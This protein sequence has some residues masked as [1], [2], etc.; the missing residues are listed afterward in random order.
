MTKWDLKMDIINDIKSN[1]H[2]RA[3][4]SHKNV[5][6]FSKDAKNH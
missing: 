1:S 3:L 4:Q 5:P 6:G 2:K